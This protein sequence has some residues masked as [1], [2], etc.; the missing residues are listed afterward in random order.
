MTRL[1][2]LEDTVDDGQPGEGTLSA[3]VERLV[4]IGQGEADERAYRYH[5]IDKYS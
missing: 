2:V 5:L 1:Y 3:N 4:G